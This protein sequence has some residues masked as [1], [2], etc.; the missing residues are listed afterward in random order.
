MLN[1]FNYGILVIR[2]PEHLLKKFSGKF[3][4]LKTDDEE[5]END[6]TLPMTSSPEDDAYMMVVAMKPTEFRRLN[7]KKDYE[8]LGNWKYVGEI[9]EISS[10]LDK[11]GIR[12]NKRLSEFSSLSGTSS[13]YNA[14]FSSGISSEGSKR[15]RYC[16]SSCF[17]R[18][19]E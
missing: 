18:K 16:I 2:F 6:T 5:D 15:D 7:D 13:G 17:I 11:S 9:G 19:K 12:G 8:I 1:F 4:A 3:T 10:R 14:D